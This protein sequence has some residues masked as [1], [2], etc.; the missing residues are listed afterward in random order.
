MI[1]CDLHDYIEIACTYKLPIRLTFL[2]DSECHTL[3]G[4]AKDIRYNAEKKECLVLGFD[5]KSA[6]AKD[7]EIVLAE[8]TSMTAL[9]KNPHFDTVSF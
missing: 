9:V 4:V 3:D 6:S 8:L 2:S 1:R 5:D 7:R